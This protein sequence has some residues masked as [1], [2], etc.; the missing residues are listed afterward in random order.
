MPISSQF[1]I[2]AEEGPVSLPAGSYTLGH[3]LL[4]GEFEVLGPAT[5]PSGRKA[6][7]PGESLQEAW[8][9]VEENTKHAPSW[10]AP[11][12]LH[13]LGPGLPDLEGAGPGT[14][15]RSSQNSWKIFHVDRVLVRGV[16]GEIYDEPRKGPSARVEGLHSFLGTSFLIFLQDEKGRI[17][18][19]EKWNFKKKGSYTSP[20]ST[21]QKVVSLLVS[22]NLP[23]FGK[24]E[25]KV[26]LN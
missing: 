7:P 20:P 1:L 8:V 18:D 24:L 2:V 16:A 22:V 10:G 12:C 4:G 9:R 3:A 26:P 13:P 25:R 23:P 5:D 21:T 19:K 17:K 14:W 11:F 15:S 6:A